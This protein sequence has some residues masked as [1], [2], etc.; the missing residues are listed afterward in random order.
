MARI[1]TFDIIVT[2]DLTTVRKITAVS[3]NTGNLAWMAGIFTFEIS[4]LNPTCL[5]IKV[6]NT[7]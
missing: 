2:F 5:F 7:R 6:Q 1:L 3:V 4:L